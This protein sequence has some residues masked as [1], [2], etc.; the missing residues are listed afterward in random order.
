MGDRAKMTF[1]RTT[2]VRLICSRCATRYEY[3]RV[4][5]VERKVT[6]GSEG[7]A[8]AEAAVELDRQQAARDFAIVRCPDCGKFAPGSI[9]NRLMM[10]GVSLGGAVICAIATV[11]LLLV[12]AETGQ[13]F[14]LLAL[15]AALGVPV[16][17]LLALVTL[18]SPTTHRTRLVLG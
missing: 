7:A 2:P 5:D 13:F 11:G 16:C 3:D 4:L 1:S 14:W 12:A 17:L 18:L 15:G 10:T 9:V 8:E 6:P